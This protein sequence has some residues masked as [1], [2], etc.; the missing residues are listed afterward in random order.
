MGTR[1]SSD[2]AVEAGGSAALAIAASKDGMWTT[3]AG[4]RAS[5]NISGGQQHGARPEAGLAWQNAAGNCGP[6]PGTASWPAAARSGSVACRWPATSALPSW[7][8]RS[9]LP[10]PATW[11]CLPRAGRATASA[12][13][14]CS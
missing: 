9:T 14:L 1:L 6:N 12:K 10:T 2:A 8:C 13:W 4:V 3:T 7:G 5:W 11:R